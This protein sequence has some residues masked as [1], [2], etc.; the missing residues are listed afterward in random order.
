MNFKNYGNRE[1]EVPGN[2]AQK[3]VDAGYSIINQ[4]NNMSLWNPNDGINTVITTCWFINT[5]PNYVLVVPS[6]DDTIE[7]RWWVIKHERI[8]GTQYRLYLYRDLI[9]DNINLVLQNDYS[10]IK[11]GWCDE[12]NNLIYNSEN[13][14]C[15]QIKR[16]QTK[17]SDETC[18]P[19]IYIYIKTPTLSELD[20]GVKYLPL[21]TQYLQWSDSTAQIG[22]SIECGIL[23]Y[24]IGGSDYK[25]IKIES[26]AQ[27]NVI[28]IPYSD[29]YFTTDGGTTI[30]SLVSKEKILQIANKLTT[31]LGDLVLDVQLLPFGA[32]GDYSWYNRKLLIDT[33]KFT[34]KGGLRWCNAT[35]A[36]FDYIYYVW[37]TISNKYKVT[38]YETYSKDTNADHPKYSIRIWDDP[39]IE[40]LI[41]YFPQVSKLNFS[42]ITMYN[43]VLKTV[44]TDTVNG[45]KLTNT[46]KTYR[47]TAPN[48]SSSWEF[49]PAKLVDKTDESFSFRADMTLMP[50][51][52]Y[53]N[54]K[55]L[56][57][58]LYGGNFTD[59][60]GLIC[61]G[62]Y[63]LP[64][65]NDNWISYIQNNKSYKDSFQRQIE[66]LEL[67]QHYESQQE[68]FNTSVSML[69][70]AVSGGVSGSSIGG[71]IGG[72][73]GGTVGAGLSMGAG[74]YSHNINN[75]LRELEKKNIIANHNDQIK[76]IQASPST[77][78]NVYTFNVDNTFFPLLEEY[79]P[80]TEDIFRFD[81]YVKLNNYNI[82]TYGKLVDYMKSNELCF[83][84]AEISL[85]DGF[86]GDS[87][88]LSVLSEEI[89]QG[90][91]YKYTGGKT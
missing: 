82:S 85:L 69:S 39:T 24:R 1:I 21:K 40:D 89:S 2:T 75:Q 30:S 48:G 29:C 13:I 88:Q 35:A 49:N 15:N 71:K 52:P 87:T 42:D 26:G 65:T 22:S 63:S 25:S 37:S 73:V 41:V 81:K 20:S 55:P 78:S 47:L 44:Y 45:L 84:S 17:L 58:R 50:Y 66:T 38:D 12:T 57:S 31:L 43:Q 51:Q 18:S 27:Y 5:V 19:W 72:I 28:C 62:D 14:T 4:V 32:L 8:A 33:T 74:I 91:Y 11:R 10:Y 6:D 90:F 7:S 76:N 61:G 3:Y 79:V 46:L 36:D 54:I 9:A 70:A 64:R 16:Y 56:F 59:Y 60:R 86:V 77:I 67:E 80:T 34:N 53:I 23:D 68:V 83:Y